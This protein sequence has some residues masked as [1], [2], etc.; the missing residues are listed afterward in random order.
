MCDDRIVVA[1]GCLTHI[2]LRNGFFFRLPVPCHYNNAPCI[3]NL[4]SRGNLHV[5]SYN[6]ILDYLRDTSARVAVIPDYFLGPPF[7]AFRRAVHDMAH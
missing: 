5:Y 3:L 1:S 4:H 6:F 7:C 2:T